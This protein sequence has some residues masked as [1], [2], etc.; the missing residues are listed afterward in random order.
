MRAAGEEYVAEVLVWATGSLSEP[1]VPEFPGLDGFRGKVFHS[2][3]WEHGLRPDEQA[4]L[5]GRHRRVGHPV[6]APDRAERRAPVPPPADAAVDR[7]PARPTDLPAAQARLPQDARAPAAVAV[8]HLRH[9]SRPCSGSSWAAATGPRR[10]SAS[11]R[12]TTCASRSPTRRLRAKLTPHYEPGC[13]RLLLSDDYYPSLTLPQRGGRRLTGGLVHRPRGR[14]PGRHRPTGRRRHHGHRLRGR[15]AS[16]RR[17]HRRPRRRP[18]LRALEGRRRRGVRRLHGGRLP[19]PLPHDRAELDLGPQLDD[20]HD[21]VAHQL[22]RQRPGLHGPA[23]RADGRGQAR[24]TAALQRTPAGRGSSTR[25]GSTAGA[26]AGTSTTAAATR[27][28]GPTTPGSSAG[29][30]GAFTPAS[31]RVRA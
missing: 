5:R 3:K 14:G 9:S 15:R 6:R 26:A 25:C 7:A 20:L 23:R 22:H 11:A 4:R 8:A 13:K 24:R 18:A 10:S 29:S 31:T 17:A 28:C 27:R 21:R 19:Q 16:L 2:A 1:Q 30:P 12:W